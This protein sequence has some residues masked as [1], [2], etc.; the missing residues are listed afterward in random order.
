VH[1]FA[2]VLI[3]QSW[4]KQITSQKKIWQK[5]AGVI[6]VKWKKTTKFRVWW[7]IRVPYKYLKRASLNHIAMFSYVCSLWKNPLKDIVQDY[8]PFPFNSNPFFLQ[9]RFWP[10]WTWIMKVCTHSYFPF[11]SFQGIPKKRFFFVHTYVDQ[12]SCHSHIVE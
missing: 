1:I 11:F 5:I 3:K 10:L 6:Y 2:L 9:F 7:R 4:K 12:C 8:Y